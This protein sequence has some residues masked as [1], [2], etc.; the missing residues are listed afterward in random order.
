[1]EYRKTG[2]TYVVRLDPGEEICDRLLWLASTE[3][4]RLAQLTGLGEVNIITLG[5][6]SPESRQYKCTTFHADFEIVSLMGNLT[7]KDG[8]PYV[9]IPMSV[10]DSSGRCYGGHL[11]HGEVNGTVELF[12]TAYDEEVAERETDPQIGLNTMRFC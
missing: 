9:H 5:N 4:I 7:R 12:I 1:M 2:N 8:K 11:N 10:S 6:Y 3:N